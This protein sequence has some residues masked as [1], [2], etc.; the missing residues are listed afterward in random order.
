MMYFVYMRVF[1]TI[2]CHLVV[3]DGVCGGI[4]HAVKFIGCPPEG[5]RHICFFNEGV[6]FS[7]NLNH[8]FSAFLNCNDGDICLVHYNLVHGS[9]LFHDR[10]FSAHYDNDYQMKLIFFLF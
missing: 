6:V 2:F 8:T 3:G 10:R 9:F 7:R 4:L 1:L 5:A